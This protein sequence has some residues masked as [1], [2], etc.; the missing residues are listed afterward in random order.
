MNNQTGLYIFDEVLFDCFPTGEEVL[1]GAP[2]NVAWHLQ[3]LGDQPSFISRVGRDDYGDRIK[4]L[5]S[6]SPS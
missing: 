5:I 4:L 6:T 1:G 3:A 2:F